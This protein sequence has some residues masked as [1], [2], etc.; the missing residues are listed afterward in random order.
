MKLE[1]MTN[2]ELASY[3]YQTFPPGSLGLL[4]ATRLEE[5]QEELDAREA[6]KNRTYVPY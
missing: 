2:K 5:A 3:C 1:A 4:L 6:D